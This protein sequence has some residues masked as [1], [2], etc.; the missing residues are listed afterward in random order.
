VCCALRLARFNTQAGADLPPY[1]APFF[2][3]VPAPGGAGL[4]IMPLFLCFQWGDWP[5]RSPYLSAVWMTAVALAMVSRLPTVSLKRVRIPHH[6]VLP[7]LL[8]IGVAT[9]AL[10]TA[11]WPTLTVVGIVYIASIPLTIRAY[12][13]LRRDY[14]AQ[15]PETVAAAAAAPPAIPSPAMI[16]GEPLPQSEWRH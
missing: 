11:P 2:C 1:A 6:Y 7:T 15:L 12:L 16:D 8:G 4:A 13:H 3:G 10:T 14:R 9:A 5:F